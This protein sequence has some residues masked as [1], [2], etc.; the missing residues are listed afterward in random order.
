MDAV[1]KEHPACIA[2]LEQL[3][4]KADARSA[5][6]ERLCISALAINHLHLAWSRFD[7]LADW[8]GRFNRDLIHA[9]SLAEARDQLMVECAAMVRHHLSDAPIADDTPAR[10][11]LNHAVSLLTQH[12]G[13]LSTSERLIAARSLL[14][15]IEIENESDGF[16]AIVMLVEASQRSKDVDMLWLGRAMIY[17]GRCYLRFNLE[18]T[19]KRF[20]ERATRLWQAVRSLAK[21]NSIGQLQFEVAHAELL[22]AVTRGEREKVSV[23][24]SEMEA[25]VD[26]ES[27]MQLADFF[28]QRAKHALQEEDAQAAMTASADAIRYTQVARAPLRQ[29]GP[30][31][32]VR[33]W[34]LA[35]GKRFDD[36]TKVLDGNIATQSG[37]PREILNCIR[38]FLVA[39]SCRGDTPDAKYLAALTTAI[40]TAQ[41]LKWPN[42]LATLPRFASIVSA[43][44]LNAG[45]APDWVRATVAQ[46][47]LPPPPF[48]VEDWPW[49]LAIRT[50]G[51]FSLKRYGAEIEFEGKVQ[52]KPLELLKSVVSVGSRGVSIAV[53]TEAV[54]PDSDAEQARAAFKVTLSRLRKLLDVADAIEIRD[55]RIALNP[56]CV[57]VDSHRFDSLADRFESS[58][59][60]DAA[61]DNS[62]QREPSAIVES[63][64]KLYQGRFLGDEDCNRWLLGARE[65]WHTKFVRLIGEAGR[66][67]ESAG[68]TTFAIRLYER[69]T[70]LDPL[71]EELHRRIIAHY[72]DQGE[73][74]EALAVFHRLKRNLALS[75]G[76]SPSEKTLALVAPLLAVAPAE[77]RHP[78]H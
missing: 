75:L 49:P 61:K 54:W 56:K 20:R 21:K 68:D 46:R 71:S 9:T 17:A 53:L 5:H 6:S 77:S 76:V 58:L 72:L 50:F 27:P 73:H 41:S 35:L 13:E 14:D 34:A 47:R 11:R 39:V 19:S 78:L 15:L 7:S 26:H 3:W 1:L 29:C 42:Y 44:A 66:H 28:M 63:I 38:L 32:L 45:I 48:D 25:T 36:A 57:Y 31:T 59:H 60:S 18:Q 40:Q 43:D 51:G 24:L 4:Q 64:L 22:D 74:A 65:R 2:T 33:V 10:P 69:A 52:K 16:E 8:L 37:R 70:A 67:F 62:K 30:H 12:A 23:L 55:S